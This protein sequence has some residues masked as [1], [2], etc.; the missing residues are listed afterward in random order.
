MAD[1]C[2]SRVPI[3]NKLAPADQERVAAL[4]QP[5]RF[6]AGEL[7]ADEHSAPRLLVVHQGR[8]KTHRLNKDGSE[9]L[10]R[11]LGTGDFTGESGVLTGQPS[12][13]RISALDDGMACSFTHEALIG[14]LRS[15]PQVALRMLATV[16]GQLEHAEDRLAA[17]TSTD[18]TTRL[19]AYLLDLPGTT[20]DG[21]TVVRLP[22]AKKDVASLLGTTPESFSRALNRLAQAGLIEVDGP[23]IAISDP[24]G[25]DELVY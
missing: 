1:L 23:E 9:Q 10:L 3:F 21:R 20:R 15:R 16:S 7:V 8:L 17:L 2:V 5:V 18:V 12:S 14:L 22:L 11:V 6:I 24:A 19:A 13:K 4:A 25:L